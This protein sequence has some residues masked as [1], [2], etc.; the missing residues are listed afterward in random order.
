MGYPG[1]PGSHISFS[2]CLQ[3]GWPG[4]SQIA[5]I[6]DVIPLAADAFVLIVIIVIATPVL[7]L[8][9]LALSARWRGPVY[10]SESRRPV[11][12]LVTEAIPEERPDEDEAADDGPKYSI[13]SPPPDPD[14]GLRERSDA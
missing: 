1:T 8:G 13:D 3:T 4:R 5:T 11:E 7:V 14:P 9:G 10:R 6:R 2:V 12:S